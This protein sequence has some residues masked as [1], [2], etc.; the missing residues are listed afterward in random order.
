MNILLLLY[1]KVTICLAFIED[2][3]VFYYPIVSLVFL[4][5]LLVISFSTS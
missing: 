4:L 3:T 2:H 5:L 1:S